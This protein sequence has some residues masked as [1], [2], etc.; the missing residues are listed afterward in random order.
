VCDVKIEARLGSQLDREV[1]VARRYVV[2][3]WFTRNVF[4]RIVAGLTRLGISV[5][6]SRV[7]EVRGRKSGE[8]RRVPVNLLMIEGTRYLVAPRGHTQWVRN[9]RVAGDGQLL[10]G[11]RRERFVASEI[12][13]ADKEPILRSYLERWKWE[14]G[15]FFGG[16]DAASPSE[17]LRRIAPDHPIFRIE[18]PQADPSSSSER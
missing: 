13:D 6:G 12:A 8:P 17:E 16:V 7:L 4:N 10:L 18:P 15:V 9:L 11:R 1:F 2:P 3:N 14:V 5:W